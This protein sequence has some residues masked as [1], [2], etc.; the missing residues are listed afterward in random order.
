MIKIKYRFVSNLSTFQSHILKKWGSNPTNQYVSQFLERNFL[1]LSPPA[2]LHHSSINLHSQHFIL[3]HYFLQA[4]KK[5]FTHQ[6]VLIF[7]A[8]LVLQ[9]QKLRCYFLQLWS[10]FRFWSN[11]C[12]QPELVLPGCW[13]THFQIKVISHVTLGNHLA[14]VSNHFLTV[15][16]LVSWS[17]CQDT[18][19][20]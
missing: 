16:P 11:S 5:F 2:S 4:T 14:F 9:V 12:F 8:Q 17:N 7:W 19:F 3:C 15:S 18:S 13:E 20:W 6:K 10:W 1:L